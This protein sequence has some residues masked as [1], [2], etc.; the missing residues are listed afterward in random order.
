MES[1]ILGNRGIVISFQYAIDTLLEIKQT[2]IR[3]IVIQKSS[4]RYFCYLKS[5]L[6]AY[7]EDKI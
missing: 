7:R 2:N 6:H 4:Y 3:Y 5:I 1:T